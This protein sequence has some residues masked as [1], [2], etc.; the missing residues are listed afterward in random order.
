MAEAKRDYYEVLGV[1]KDADEATLKKAYRQV[2][3]KYHP[4]MNPGDTEAEKKFKEASEAY[5][6]LSD[7]EKRRQYDQYGHAAFEGGAGGAGGFGGFDFGGADFSDI[8]G[9]IFGDLFGGGGRRGRAS[10]GPMKGANIRKSVRI[11]FEEAVFGCEKE[12]DVVL[13]DPCTTCG[14]SGAKPGTSP[15]TCPKCGGKGQ[16]VYTQQSFFGTVQ[17]VQTCPDCHGTG[18][19]VREKCPDCGGTGYVSNRKKIS[20]TIPAGIDNGQ[21]VRIREKGEPGVNGGPRGDLLVEVT[22]SR[23]PIFQRQDMHIFSTVPI[24]FAQA[25]LGADIRIKTVDGDVIYTVKPGTKTDTKVRLKGKGIPSV[26]N[27]QVRGDH[28]VTLVIQ[29]PEHLSHEAKEA[30]RKFDELAGNTLN[31]VKDDAGEKSGKKKKGFMD[32]MKEAFDD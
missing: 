12:L 23:H 1:S 31:V 6:V 11:T 17:N 9:D 26:R 29:T 32:K 27:S 16:V 14:G 21:S 22:V 10:Q 4:D 5:A 8:F 18:K 25:A 20:V 3:K 7:P 24:S 19:I 13:K 30:L 28:Y 15:E 2:A